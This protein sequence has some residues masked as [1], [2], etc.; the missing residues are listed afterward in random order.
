MSN[1]A[2][3]STRRRTARRLGCLALVLIAVLVAGA[4]MAQPEPNGPSRD[5]LP[6]AAVARFE[7][8]RLVVWNRTI[9]T[10]RAPVG[11]ITPA[12]RARNAQRRIEGLPIDL[13]SGEIEVNEAD[14]D[15]MHG[16][17]IHGAGATLFGLLDQ[18]IDLLSGETLEIAGENAKSQLRAV[19][20]ARL[21]Q[22]RPSIVLRA[23]VMAIGA[24][25]VIVIVFLIDG[26]ARVAV[27][28]KLESMTPSLSERAVGF[29]LRPALVSTYRAVL[30]VVTWGVKI[31]VIYLAAAI[32]L[33]QLPY[34]RP[35]GERLGGYFTSLLL[36]LG[37]GGIQALPGLLA[38]VV[39]FVGARFVSRAIDGLLKGA[40]DGT[41]AVPWLYPSTVPATRRIVK[42]VIWLFAI[43]VAYPYLPASDTAAFK[44]LSV[45]AG[46]ML[47][48]GSSGIVNQLMSGL[49]LIYSRAF[50]PGDLVMVGD[51][52][53]FVTEIGILSTKI[54]TARREQITIPNAVVIGNKVTNYLQETLLAATVTIG[55]A[56]PWRQ[57]HAMLLLAA[58]RTSGLLKDPAPYVLQRALSDFYVEYELRCHL[59][60]PME[61]I[62]ILSALHGQIQDAFNEFGV[63]IMVPHFEGQ[64]DQPVV[65]A[66]DAWHAQP[67]AAQSSALDIGSPAVP[68]E[69]GSGGPTV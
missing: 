14:V 58:E 28:R 54:Q 50:K 40:E 42:V 48:L 39:I 21:E 52:F 44:G 16:V 33:R 13:L 61:R 15:G 29:D 36:Q 18:D 2:D 26:R 38:A 63:Q 19:F 8:A 34:T 6:S 53:G 45:L 37:S 46:A 55:Y 68:A 49:V 64:P 25:V 24:I 69:G 56:A 17:L 11:A 9:A 1:R 7:P 20:D 35:W 59:E 47:T 66:R 27:H 12:E 3:D 32:V 4:A 31:T 22:H 23:I 62:A 43:S 10:F 65:V 60:R 30:G 51:T 5:P 41:I 67:A 57:V